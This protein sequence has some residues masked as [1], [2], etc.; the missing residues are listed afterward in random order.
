MTLDGLIKKYIR[1]AAELPDRTSP[2][3]YPDCMLISGPEL[4]DLLRDFAC[5]FLGND[6]VMAGGLVVGKVIICPNC[7]AKRESNVGGCWQCGIHSEHW[8]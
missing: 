2:E 4:D 5:D 7:S 3:D 8:A 1:R 6:I